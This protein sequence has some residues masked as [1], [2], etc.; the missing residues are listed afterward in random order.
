MLSAHS[1]RSRYHCQA[2]APASTFQEFINVIPHTPA[3]LRADI[4]HLPTYFTFE[5]YSPKQNSESM[6]WSIRG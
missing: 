6:Q 3:L 2:T 4:T 5:W 1:L